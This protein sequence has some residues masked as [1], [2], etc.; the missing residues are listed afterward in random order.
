[1][2]ASGTEPVSKVQLQFETL[3][4]IMYTLRFRWPLSLVLSGTVQYCK[5]LISPSGN[6]GRLEDGGARA[7]ASAHRRVPRGITPLT[8]ASQGK[9]SPIARTCCTFHR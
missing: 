9:M 3:T 5:L 4:T 2:K 7:A 8:I 6:A 1:L